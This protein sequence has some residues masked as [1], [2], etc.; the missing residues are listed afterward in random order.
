[1][2]CDEYPIGVETG[3]TDWALTLEQLPAV[4]SAETQPRQRQR[5]AENQKLDV[6]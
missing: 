1:M 3:A 6:I 4:K 2:G 5:I